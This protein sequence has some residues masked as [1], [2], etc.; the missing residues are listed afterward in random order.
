MK[1]R[2]LDKTDTGMTKWKYY[3]LCT[4]HIAHEATLR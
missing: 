2:W 1:Q 3:S 4:P